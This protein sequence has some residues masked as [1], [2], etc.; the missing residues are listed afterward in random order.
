[1]IA[2]T[3]SSSVE[4]PPMFSSSSFGPPTLGPFIIWTGSA[5]YSSRVLSSCQCSLMAQLHEDTRPD[6]RAWYS[7]AVSRATAARSCRKPADEASRIKRH[8]SGRAPTPEAMPVMVMCATMKGP[9]MIEPPSRRLST[10]SGGSRPLP[11]LHDSISVHHSIRITRE[12]LQL[13]SCNA[14]ICLRPWRTSKNR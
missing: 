10:T 9:T 6:G 11:R 8:A 12:S 7:K 1:M 3:G 14:E 2:P 13:R 4:P 5:L